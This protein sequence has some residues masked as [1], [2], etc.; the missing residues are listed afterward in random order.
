[1]GQFPHK[2]AHITSRLNRT[3]DSS[4]KGVISLTMQESI[5]F[6]LAY[7]QTHTYTQVLISK[8]AF[9]NHKATLK[10]KVFYN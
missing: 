10:N 8:T 5:I 1:M 2:Y 9:C 3:Q 6:F 7:V 4:I